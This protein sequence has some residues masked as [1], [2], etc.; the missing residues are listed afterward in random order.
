M[1]SVLNKN[2]VEWWLTDGN[3]LGMRR[4]KCLLKWDDDIDIAIRKVN[5]DQFCGVFKELI[6]VGIRVRKNRFGVYWQIDE[7]SDFEGK[8]EPVHIDCFLFHTVEGKLQNTDERFVSNSVD[9]KSL[10]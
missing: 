9:K 8:L 7:P 4:G 3:L 1:I 2:K 5:E 6:E 10:T